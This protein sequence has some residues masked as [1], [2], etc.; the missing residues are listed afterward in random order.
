MAL[1][2][3]VSQP[4]CDDFIFPLTTGR[5]MGVSGAARHATSGW[6]SAVLH[7]ADIQGMMIKLAE[8]LSATNRELAAD[9]FYRSKMFGKSRPP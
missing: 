7:I 8:Q 5:L 4:D 2:F 9:D 3:V 6:V 1:C